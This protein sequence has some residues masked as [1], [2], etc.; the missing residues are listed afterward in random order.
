M[1]VY[2]YCRFQPEQGSIPVPPLDKTVKTVDV[3][4]N[5]KN[6]EINHDETYNRIFS[7]NKNE[8]KTV[9]SNKN[10]NENENE[11]NNNSIIKE[12]N[13][14]QENKNEKK[15]KKIV[16]NFN[17]IINSLSKQITEE[18]FF[19]L[20]K[21]KIKET[22]INLGQINES[23]K[24]DYLEKKDKDII[25]HSPLFF[26]KDNIYYFG[27]WNPKNIKKEGWG[28]LIDKD[29]NKYEGGWAN[30]IMDGYGR[31]LS[32]NGDY[33]EGDIKSGIIEGN[34]IF[35]LYE[36]KI[37][38]KGE[39][40]NNLFEGKGE[41]V[42]ENNGNKL[43]YEG[44][45]KE[46]KREGNGKFI[47]EDEILYEGGFVNDKFNGEG[48]FKWKDGRQ[49]KGK[50]KDNQINGKGIF[51]WD[52]NISYEGDYKNNRREGYGTYHFGENNYYEGKWLNNLPHG[53]GKYIKDGNIVEGLFRFGKI[54]KNKNGKKK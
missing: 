32:K 40:K 52:N 23:K 9:Q 10:D 43:I 45:F 37:L 47:F 15:E 36:K 33:Y 6:E 26:E 21:E 42:Y 41:Q 2:C 50:W 48:L 13:N 11:I 14:N 27:S 5:I 28:T 24:N 3:S 46:G 25:F 54:I 51:T 29:G 39:F 30:D 12:D 4:N 53:E 16:L 7:I 35:Y 20:T 19:S 17:K 38:Y 22:E 44:M 8:L 1:G 49:Y 31:I 34:G 18:E